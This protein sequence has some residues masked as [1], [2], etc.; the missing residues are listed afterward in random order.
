MSTYQPRHAAVDAAGSTHR[1]L[2]VRA[3]LATAVVAGAGIVAPTSALAATRP[4]LRRGSRGTAVRTLQNRLKALGYSVGTVD[5]IFGAKTDTAVRAFQ[6]KKRLTADGIVGA[7]TWAALYAT[8]TTTTP[9][10]QPAPGPAP[11]GSTPTLKSGSTGAAVRRL[12]QALRANGYWLSSVDG[13]YGQTTQQAVM[14]VQKYH[15]LTR[16]G[17][18]GPA[19][20]RAIN[21]L[22]RP[23][24]RTTSGTI[25]EVDLRRQLL[26]FVVSGKVR[27]VFNTST[28]KTR[29][30]TPRGRWR[31]ER[32]ING[33][34][35]A[36][37]GQL[38]RP[39]YWWR[40]YAIHGATSI[41]GYP[42]SSGCARV[43]NAGMNYI[44]SAGLA[45]IGRRI[46]VY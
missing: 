10:P 22:S 42:A 29:T 15:G 26:F 30:P 1:R 18:C 43:S 17:V 36:P 34:R 31:I 45:P 4:T 11:T 37:L 3:G 24:A 35:N 32:Q 2:L 12:Q 39:K 7:K 13:R 27:W 44:W 6:R 46:W 25:I 41:P 9:A 33:M 20:W 38:W 16:D 23:R 21:R 19:T 8:P 28:G 40:G 14:A 5:G